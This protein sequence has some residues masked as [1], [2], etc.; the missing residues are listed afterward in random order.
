MPVT[1][2]GTPWL[3]YTLGENTWDIVVGRQD[4]DH[5]TSAPQVSLCSVW[6]FELFASK[7]TQSL[8]HPLIIVVIIAIMIEYLYENLES[9]R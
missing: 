3:V 6:S 9:W 5:E 1:E 7:G 4:N 8:V 2:M